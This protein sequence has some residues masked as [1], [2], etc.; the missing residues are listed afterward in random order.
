MDDYSNIRGF[1]YQP[2]WGSCGLETFGPDFDADLVAIEMGRGKKYFPGINTLRIWLSHQAFLRY[3]AEAFLSRLEAM[4]AAGD[5]WL[6]Q[7]A[8]VRRHHQRAGEQLGGT[9]DGCIHAL[10]GSGS[11]C[12][13]RRPSHPAMGLMQRANEQRPRSGRPA[14]DIQLAGG[15]QQMRQSQ[16]CHCTNLHRLDTHAVTGSDARAALRCD[17]LASLLRLECLDKDSR[18]VPA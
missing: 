9:G 8:A 3:G 13:R 11:R 2:S 10:R 16:W 5:A 18:T 12:T 4:L 15:H 7:L 17:H 6:A 14:D 1:N